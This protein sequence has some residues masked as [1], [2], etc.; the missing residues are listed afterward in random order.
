MPGI[1]PVFFWSSR[2]SRTRPLV[3]AACCAPRIS[4]TL[5]RRLRTW[6]TQKQGRQEKVWKQVKNGAC[7]AAEKEWK[8]LRYRARTVPGQ[9]QKSYNTGQ[10]QYLCNNRKDMIQDKHSTCVTTEKVWYRTKTVPAQQQK[11]NDTRTNTVPV[12]Q[13]KRHDSGQKNIPVQQQK[14]NDTGQKQC[15]LNNRKGMIQD[16]NSTYTTTEKVWYRTKNSTCAT[17]EK[18]QIQGISLMNR[19]VRKQSLEP[20]QA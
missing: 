14:R 11:K 1:L 6:P 12:W 3:L 4:S 17:T 8:E 15:L 18:E 9:Q 2:K 5:H 20:L 13:Q 16:K 7:A 19:T 10:K